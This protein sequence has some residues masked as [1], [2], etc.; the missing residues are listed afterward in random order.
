MQRNPKEIKKLSE[1]YA[2]MDFKIIYDSSTYIEQSLNTVTE[3]AIQG[4]ILA[5]LVLYLFLRNVRATLII[6]VSMPVSIIT[7]FV[8]M[9][10]SGISLNLISLAGFAWE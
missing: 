1:N 3:S 9:Y 8:L 10:F 5:V 6:A 7:S 2:E 4:G